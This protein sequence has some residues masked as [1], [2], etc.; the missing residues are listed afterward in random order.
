MTQNS[1][2]Y[3]AHAM[4]PTPGG[5]HD[6]V[7]I[8]GE[9][10]DI[11]SR[12]RKMVALGDQMQKAANTLKHLADGTVGK[13]L[14]IDKLQESAEGVYS[15]LK[16]AGIRYSPSGEV[17]AAYGEAL[18]TVQAPIITIVS[19]CESLWETVRTASTALDEA[20]N[21]GDDT[22]TLQTA[23][24]EA[25]WAWNTEARRYNAHYDTWSA[26][27]ENARSG[28]QDANDNGV[29]DS[30]LD[31][32]LPALDVISVVLTWAGI[33]LAIAA[34]IL[35][36]PFILAAALIGLAA[37]GV[38]LLRAAGGRATGEDIMWAAV[39]VFPFGKAFG[40]IKGVAAASGFVGRLSA[41]GRGG[42][43]ML[44]DVFGLGGGSSIRSL[45]GLLS[46][47]NVAEVFHGSGALNRNGSRV[48]Q[49]WFS[50]TGGPSVFNR[51]M[52]G[53]DGATGAHLADAASN[54]SN[55]AGDNLMQFLTGPNGSQPIADLMTAG[56][57]TVDNVLNFVD[58]MGK[59]GAGFAHD[60]GW[61]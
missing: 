26:A 8:Y 16:K 2:H 43:S 34:C 29:E 21:T 51:L 40:A 3:R 1:P 5:G 33:A 53:F 9:A 52:Q 31:N 30:L 50:N 55:K 57:G 22:A 6:L 12:G 47:G 38:T 10:D 42:L 19:N 18:T 25:V 48:L 60:M 45:N 20:E 44:G 37:L 14:S 56:G 54:L 58:G 13:G 61:I 15:D 7:T 49:E 11:T 41:A 4:P 59:S 32:M 35:G 24:D 36:G 23:F 17:I 46:R 39:G 27:Y 28:L